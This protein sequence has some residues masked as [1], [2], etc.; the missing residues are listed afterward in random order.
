LRMRIV[1]RRDL[2]ARSTPFLPSCAKRCGSCVAPRPQP[3]RIGCRDLR[4][5]RLRKRSAFFCPVVKRPAYGRHRSSLVAS[6]NAA[7][8]V[9]WRTESRHGNEF[10]SKELETVEMDV[11]ERLIICTDSDLQQARPKASALGP[12]PARYVRCS[13]RI[14][15]HGMKI[16]GGRIAVSQKVLGDLSQEQCA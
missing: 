2:S 16:H 10:T 8:G 12:A 5:Y 6:S 7:I 15:A 11:R 9:R 14:T 3:P 4:Q 13:P 1:L